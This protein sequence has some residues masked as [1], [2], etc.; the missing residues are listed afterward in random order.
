MRIR[1]LVVCLLAVLLLAGGALAQNGVLPTNIPT[2]NPDVVYTHMLNSNPYGLGSYNASTHVFSMTGAGTQIN[3]P[4]AANFCSASGCPKPVMTVAIQ[5]DN[6]GALIGGNPNAALPDF[7]LDGQITNGTTTYTSPLLTGKITEFYY[8]GVNKTANFRLRFAVTGGSMAPLYLNPPSLDND[9][10]MYLFL[11]NLSG[12]TNFSGTFTKNFGGQSK[13]DVFGTPGECLGKIGD[14][15]WNDLNGDGIQDPT[16]SGLDGITVRLYDSSNN[17]LG[18][19]VTH[20][21]PTGSVHGYYQFTGVCAG[22]YTVKVDE[23]TLPPHFEATTPNAPGSNPTNDSNPNP[24]TVTLTS[25]ASVDETIDFGYV[26]MQ[27][28]IG[29]YVWYDANHNGVQDAG[30]HGINGVVVKLWDSTQTTLLATTTTAFGGPS[31]TDGYYQFTGLDEGNYVVEVDNSTLPPNYSPTTPNV[32][33]PSTDSNGSPASVN[34]PTD[35]SSD[36]TIDFGYVTPCNGKIG[37]FVW[38]D[39]DRDGVQGSGEPGINGV[40]LYLYDSAHNKIQTAIT[41]PN[42]YYEFDGVCDGTYEVDVDASTLPPNFTPTTPHVGDS[43]TDSN[44]SP[45]PVTLTLDAS[46]NVTQ[47]LTIDF[48]YVSPCDGAIGDFVWLDLNGNGIQDPG[49]N[50]ISNVE[51]RLMDSQGH[52]LN[53]TTTGTGYYQ[54]TGLCAGTYQVEVVPPVGYAASPVNAAGS[55]PDNDSN[56][57]PT[58][59]VLSVIN[60]N[61]DVTVDESNDFGFVP[62]RII[63]KKFT[64]P[65]GSPQG[66]QFTPSYN[67]GATFSLT[68]GTSNDSGPLVAGSYSVAE[69]LPTN[70][71]QTSASCDNGNKPDAVNLAAGQTVTCTFK[72]TQNGNIV[73]NKV[74]APHGSSQNFTFNTTGTGYAGFSLT[75]GTSNDSGPLVPGSYSVSEQAMT[76]WDLTSAVCDG[77]NTPGAIKLLAGQTV[78]CTFTNTQRAKLIVVKNAI[79]GND[80]FSFV[81]TGD[82]VLSA[83]SLTTVSGTASIFFDNLLPGSGYSVTENVGKTWQLTSASCDSGSPSVITLAAGQTVTCIFT[84]TKY[85]DVTGNCVVISAVQGFPITP[86][87]M[88]ASGGAGGPYTFSATGLPT[89]IVMDSD[90]TIHG[91]PTVTGIFNYTVTVTDKNGNVGTVN[92]S[93]TVNT[94]PTA[95]CVSIT[96]VQGFAIAPVQMTGSG[97]TGGPYTF[98]ATGLP[99]GLMMASDGTISGTPTVSGTFSYTVTVTDKDGHTGTV[100]CSVTVNTPPTASCVSITAVQNVAITPVKMT[101]SGG[102]GGPYTFSATGLPTGLTMASDG[103]I[104]G[105]PTVSGTF[106]YTV[107]VTDKDGHSS[108][109]NCSV[110]VLPPPTASCVSIAAIQGVA[111]APVKMNGSGGTGGPYTFSATGLPAGLTM[112]S[113]GTIHGTPTVNGTF[114]YVV[115]VTDKDGHS[116]TVNCSVTVLPPVSATCVVINAV[117]GIAITPVKMTASGGT[118]TGYTFSA[119][120]LP[121]GLTMDADGTI[122]GTPTVSG[123]FNYTVTVTDSAGNKGTF[124]CSVTVYPPISASCVQIIATQGVTITPVQMTASGGVGGPYTFSASGLPNGLTM[125]ADGTIHGTPTVN[126]TFNYTVTVKDKVGNIGLVNC[127]VFVNPPAPPPLTLLCP[128]ATGQVGVAYNSAA[129]AAGGVPPY[130]FAV[131]A[132]ALP[133]GLSLN[134][135]TGAIT[136]TP[137]APGSFAFSIKVTDSIG[138]TATSQCSGTCTSITSLWDFSA[139]LGIL[140]Y[141]QDYTVNGLTITAYG[142]TNGG[143]QTKLYGK[144]AGGDENGVGL[145]YTGNSDFEID[146]AHFVQLDL[147]KVIASGATSAQMKVGSVQ[148]G[149]SYNIYGSNSLGSIGTQLAGPLTADDT[150]FDV[151]NYGSYRYVSVRAASHDVLLEAFSATLPPGCTIVVSPSP[152]IVACPANTGKVGVPYVSAV[153]ASGGV[154]PYTFSISA[155]SLPPGL[156]LNSTTGA[157]TGTP[158]TAGTYTFTTKV[159]DANNGS[160]VSVSKQCTITIVKP[161]SP[162]VVS[163]PPTKN[164]KVGS[165]FSTTIPVTGGSAP[166]TFSISSGSLPPGL[167]LDPTTGVISGTPTSA[168]S[169]SFTI[170]VIDAAGNIVYSS[171]D[172]GCSNISEKFDFLKECGSFKHSHHY[173]NDGIDLD[174]HGFNKDGS[175][176]NLKCRGNGDSDDGVGL[177]GNYDDGI[178]SNS[179]VQVDVSNLVSAGASDLQ[180]T[181]GS[182]HTGETYNVYGSN[183]LGELGSLILCNQKADGSTVHVP[184]FPNHK[185]ICIRANHKCVH[186]K[187]VTSTHP[188]QCTITIAPKTKGCTYTQGGWGSKPSGNN[189]GTI[190][191]NN[192][193]KVYGFGGVSIGG[194]YTDTFTNSLAV[195]NFLPAGGTPNAL[196]GSSTN[197]NSAWSVFHGEVLALQLNVDFSNKGITPTGLA[198]LHLTSGSLQGWTVQQVLNLAN[199][200]LGGNTWALPHGMSVSD[201]NNVVDS[202]NSSLDGGTTDT[203]Y[204]N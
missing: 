195:Q 196:W 187:S 32:G 152:L 126:G 125:D 129:A 20:I 15:V 108:T 19:D 35:S 80:V 29:D 48:G 40:T 100:N 183:R 193:N 85:P 137:T 18:T 33:S 173:N 69:A 112:D 142:F 166:F 111:I 102:T 185:Y 39:L 61:G 27:G 202:I 98:S 176:R 28:A 79:G 97:G 37:D 148:S 58:T 162:P 25:N 71:I 67:G 50:G 42:G 167:T 54:F 117:Q 114:N 14:Y 43:S 186:L 31:N 96:A 140:G 7:E 149:E 180:V 153:V 5:V 132:G 172:S 154:G 130:T 51:V 76:G 116:G 4:P 45:A 59:V 188:C 191:A 81:S 89:G 198:G 3:F 161:P 139:P 177:D 200:V 95:S 158:T 192:W 123:T 84:N 119:S 174:V 62:G 165:S 63:V 115:T 135:T 72:N 120:G 86:I 171:C 106:N 194:W 143:A 66:F 156:T 21:G 87:Q 24:S 169:F 190:L 150:Y 163:C 46:N 134:T 55:T 91:T 10:W 57:N 23:T 6:T 178:D 9:L 41:N 92:C 60:S 151:P 203:G 179:F 175:W 13:G 199:Q 26:A 2:S 74:T 164:G 107:T 122:H 11:E 101:G 82:G 189:P 170:K 77:G 110:T 65:A 201:L 64:D 99:T 136:G 73:V 90:G 93:V 184:S 53:T 124:H 16:E 47:D 157:I 36:E 168:G 138:Q 118:G 204:L 160:A 88:P 12:T 145:Y 17:V 1:T 105:A 113:D 146:T 197:P 141:S 30:E 83:F 44:G 56:P 22:T 104:S 75:D 68:D 34:L 78:H 103:T 109:V 133:P 144:Q 131:A 121:T 155:G 94:P 127:S 159:T 70:W 181:V 49:E 147:Q 52:V 128:A 8:D 182:I 38:H